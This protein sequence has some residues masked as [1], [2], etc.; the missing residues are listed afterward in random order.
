MF[1]KHRVTL[2]WLVAALALI[3]WAPAASA[4]PNVN[5]PAKAKLPAP[6]GHG[7]V[8]SSSGAPK[9]CISKGTELWVAPFGRRQ[10]KDVITSVVLDNYVIKSDFGDHHGV[11]NVMVLP[12]GEYQF[13]PY[14]L[15]PWM[16]FK[17]PSRGRFSVKA[18]ETVYIGETFLSSG[19]GGG[20][21]VIEVRDQQVRD[22]AKLK[23]MRPD[24][25]TAGIVK[26]LA[27]FD[28]GTVDKK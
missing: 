24:L 4:F 6:A 26:R 17:A 19:C 16:E 21:V 22:L 5:G 28:G 15:N 25:D 23:Q 2:S 11:I 12:E 14:V 13:Y 20:G 7:V 9:T 1:P 3:L 10:M 8:V 18:G 27:Y